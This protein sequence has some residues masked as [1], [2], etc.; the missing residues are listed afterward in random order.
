MSQMKFIACVGC[1]AVATLVLAQGGPVQIELTPGQKM[2]YE[3]ELTTTYA[4][5]EEGRITNRVTTQ[6]GVDYT[7]LEKVEEGFKLQSKF[8]KFESTEIDMT[9]K[10]LAEQM[11]SQFE[12]LEA[13]FVVSPRGK[14]SDFEA[15]GGAKFG[16]SLLGRFSGEDGR[17][18]YFL[19]PEQ[20]L[21]QG[22][23]WSE[24][25][26]GSAFSGTS[27]G[28]SSINSPKPVMVNYSVRQISG[29]TAIINIEGTLNDKMDIEGP[30]T[31]GAEGRQPLLSSMS[32]VTE[33]RVQG[34]ARVDVR[35]GLVQ[36][37]DVTYTNTISSQTGVN[38]QS[39]RYVV[40][41][42]GSQ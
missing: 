24:E 23:S 15:T 25:V 10:T 29:D 37:Y 11:K 14:V 42:A 30:S 8:N 40:R 17:F 38:A 41:A 26:S 16:Q 19:L 7:V 35:T 31:G 20:P 39:N 28:P 5:G 27:F 21:T 32:F 1:V 6:A 3:F 22:A 12:G 18:L 36:L 9:N 34:Q 4:T 33:A 13:T 2:S